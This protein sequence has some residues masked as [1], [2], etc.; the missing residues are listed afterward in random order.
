MA[1]PLV[2][3]NG[4]FLPQS[5][6]TLR[7]HDAGLVFGATVTD[8]CRSFGHKLFRLAGHLARF[9]QS[10]LAARIAQPV[11]DEALGQI[12]G[13]LVARNAAFLRP[14]QDLAL[15][16]FATPGPIGYYLGQP[17]GPGDGPPTLGLH[18]FPIP[19]ERYAPLFERGARLVVPTTH[20]VPADCVDPRI[21][22]RSRLHWWLAEQQVREADPGASALLLDS[23][24]HMTETA[25]ANLL[26]VREG[27]VLTP[28]RDTVLNGVSLQT[29]EEL[30]A[31]LGIPFHEQP[32]AVA[33]CLAAQE[34][35]LSSTTFCLAG[36]SRI[37]G[38]AL[39]WPGPVQQRLLARWSER[40]GLE[41]GRQIL[42]RP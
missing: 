11:P 27:T 1:E 7:L 4:Q 31:E 37:N 13:D 32:L 34:A 38:Q 9:R 26:I 17:G 14:E 22:Q 20:A 19:F 25:A 40:V 18:T 15:V 42:P 12:A 24:G 41:I 8:L 36:V 3:L 23:E 33:D 6:A 21:K 10:C 29:V 2:Y 35:M 5:Q 30:C 16:L 28:P 39:P